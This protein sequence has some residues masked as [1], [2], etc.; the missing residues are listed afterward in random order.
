M[1]KLKGR[2]QDIV[3][4]YTV[5][6]LTLRQIA[7]LMGVSHAGIAR[8][9]KR[10]GIAPHQGEWAA[11]TCAYCGKRFDIHR[12]RYLDRIEHYCC[13]E[14][15]YASRANPHYQPDAYRCRLARAIVA[16]HYPLEPLHEVHHVDGN[17][18]NNDLNNLM[19]FAN[20]SDHH[21]HHHQ[22]NKAVPVWIGSEVRS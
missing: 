16:Q 11:V 1:G 3:G 7:K 15:Y 22:K 8:V 18:S 13:A 6:H 9:L 5:Q 12:K 10:E 4:M 20:A 19:V 14:H 2:T 21:K 17:Q